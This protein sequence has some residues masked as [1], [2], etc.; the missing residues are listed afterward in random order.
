MR[1]RVIRASSQLVEV[2]LKANNVD[3]CLHRQNVHI[4]FPDQVRDQVRIY[5]GTRDRELIC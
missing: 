5:I 2:N 4:L 3:R 1:V